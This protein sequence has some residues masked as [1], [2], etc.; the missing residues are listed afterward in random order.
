MTPTDFPAALRREIG[1]RGF[2][3]HELARRAGVSVSLLSRWQA[4][5]SV[6]SADAFCK[7]ADALG[8]DVSKLRN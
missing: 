5:L 1:R 3:L 6:P 8:V 4:G 7:V 2:T